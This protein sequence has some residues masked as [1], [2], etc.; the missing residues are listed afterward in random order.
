MYHPSLHLYHHHLHHHPHRPHQ[1]LHYIHP[2]LQIPQQLQIQ[3]MFE[4]LRFRLKLI[5]ITLFLRRNNKQY[6]T[7][8][9]GKDGSSA[10]RAKRKKDDTI[11]D[12][13]PDT[14]TYVI[15]RHISSF[16]QFFPYSYRNPSSS[17]KSFNPVPNKS[18]TND[19][20]SVVRTKKSLSKN[21][22]M[23]ESF[24]ASRSYEPQPVKN[25]TIP[26]PTAK[27]HASTPPKE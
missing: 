5:L 12:S 26:P 20:S 15:I 18:N 16:D 13:H 21:S 14:L 27:N 17:N 3:R 19:Q 8:K 2:N 22:T 11:K 25:L 1:Q 9:S 7:N 6:Q 23:I 10:K 4:N 24:T